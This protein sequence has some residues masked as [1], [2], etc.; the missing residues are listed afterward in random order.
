MFR[1][2]RSAARLGGVAIVLLIALY[3]VTNLAFAATPLGPPHSSR[4]FRVSG[5]VKGLHPG[6][7]VRM[8]AKIQNTSRSAIIVTSIVVKVGNP[9]NRCRGTNVHIKP[10]RGG[11][12]VGAGQMSSVRLRVRMRRS[13]PDACQDVRFPLTFSAKAVP[14]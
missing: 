8:R 9:S 6:A 12:H 11:A 4:A 5:R 3:A 7:R 13:A 2:D 10:F 1:S 14:A